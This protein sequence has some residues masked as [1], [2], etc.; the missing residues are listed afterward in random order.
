MSTADFY[1]FTKR[2]EAAK[3]ACL[4]T[5]TTAYRS[6]GKNVTAVNVLIA[7]QYEDSEEDAFC[8]TRGNERDKYKRDW[9]S[10]R[11]REREFCVCMW[12]RARNSS[13]RKREKNE[14]YFRFPKTAASSLGSFIRWYAAI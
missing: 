1:V 9:K 10:E 6:R 8:I 7:S 3:W 5:T 12:V 11:E 2:Y 14:G 13:S 4:D